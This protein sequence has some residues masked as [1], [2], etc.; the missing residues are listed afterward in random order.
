EAVNIAGDRV[1]TAAPRTPPT[2][3][4]VFDDEDVTMAMAKTLIKMKEEKV[5]EKGV[6]IKD[7]RQKKVQGDAHIER[8]VEV[9]L[10]LQA[11]L[12]KEL[13][14]ERERQKEAS[15]VVIA[16]MFDE[17][18]AR[19]D[20]DYELAARMTQE[21]QEKYIIKERAKL[22]AEFFKRRKKQLAAE[23]AEAIK[24]KPPTKTQLR[25]LMMTYL[26]NMGGYR[27]SQLKGKSY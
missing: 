6:A 17:V 5:K 14:V 1:S 15:K 25:N 4:T 12:D 16:D 23:R 27:H 24:S 8:D 9:A 2:T 10:R 18:Q 20:V 7:R 3:I 13:K 21:E 22:L 11:K 26:N 19:I